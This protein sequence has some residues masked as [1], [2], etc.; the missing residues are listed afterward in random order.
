MKTRFSHLIEELRNRSV[1]RA[2]VVYCVIAWLAL[3]VADVT[4][5]QLPIPDGAMT[6]MIVLAILGLPVT[7]VVAWAYE[8]TLRGIVRHEETGGGAPK[9]AFLPFT[10]LVVTLSAGLAYALYY[11]SSDVQ[12][13]QP[14][15][16]AVLPFENMSVEEDA[17]FSDGLTE[18]IRSLMVRLNQFR[19]VALSSI[20]DLRD[21]TIDVPTIARR[22]DVEYLIQGSVR[23][24]ADQVRIT[25]R[26][27]DGEN[28][29]EMWSDSYDRNLS[30]IFVIQED[31][32]RR[33]ASA[34]QIVLPV[35]IER[36]LATRG[37]VNIEA[38]D[39]YL[40]AT[41]YLR[42]PA[43]PVTLDRT[44]EY[45]QRSI[46]V[47]PNFARPYAALCEVNLTRYERFRATSYFEDAERACHRALTR[48]ANATD[49]HLALGNLYTY[50]GQY[51]EAI[52]RFEAALETNEYLPDAHIGIA[53]VYQQLNQPVE[54]EANL[55]RAINLDAS[56]WASFNELGALLFTEG[57]YYEAA[58]FFLEYARRAEDNATAY[59]NLGAAFYLAGDFARAAEAWDRSLDIK[60][61]SGAYAN[62]GSMYF[63]LGEFET[64][65]DRYALGVGLA[66][67]DYRLWGA[68]GDAYFLFRQ[69]ELRGGNGLSQ[70]D[71]VCGRKADRQCSR[72]GRDL[73]CRLL[74]RESRAGR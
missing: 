47:D 39:L 11:L 14:P 66:P 16:V 43:D 27:I 41:D 37:T 36:T 29:A 68:L 2:T 55:R 46:N 61:T 34:L 62:T 57:R 69:P 4:F 8:I 60:P 33:V 63:Y 49:V 72:C 22:L 9:L 31:I 19:V 3:Q 30:D 1:F 28:G 21:K 56:Y 44:E 10:L 67:L 13:P 12:E 7:I 70:S 45:I 6:G 24:A 40:R 17:Y 74:L 59:N 18:E 5:D 20:Y 71:P 35:S 73:R 15:A 58:D 50:S 52:N 25:I 26:L 54:A 51:T 42:Q 23:R 32:A 64:A 38:Y 53:E 65:A 48:D